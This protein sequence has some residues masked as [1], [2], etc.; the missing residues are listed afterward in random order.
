MVYV[1]AFDKRRRLSLKRNN[2][3]IGTGTVAGSRAIQH[4]LSTPMHFVL[5]PVIQ[6]TMFFCFFVTFEKIKRRLDW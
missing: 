2:F 4:T 3:G 1:H 5:V 6:T